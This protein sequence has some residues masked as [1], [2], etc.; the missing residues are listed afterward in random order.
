MRTQFR[1]VIILLL[2]QF[3][4]LC[5]CAPQTADP[6]YVLQL[7]TK[8]NHDNL[9]DFHAALEVLV[10]PDNFIYY[11]DIAFI[12]SFEDGAY[13]QTGGTG[14][15]RYGIRDEAG[16]PITVDIREN[17]T[18]EISQANLFTYGGEPVY[19]MPQRD[20]FVY[21]PENGPAQRGERPE[22]RKDPDYWKQ[23]T[24]DYYLYNGIRY[25][26]YGIDYHRENQP[27]QSGKIYEVKW[28]YGKYEISLRLGGAEL[29]AYSGEY[30]NSFIG[31]LLH[32]DT[33]QEA[34]DQINHAILWR[35]IQV[36]LKKDAPLLIC[37]LCVLSAGTVVLVKG[38][39][40][41]KSRKKQAG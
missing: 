24:W 3:L 35:R 6:E 2:L 8:E 31:K 22:D 1:C 26:Y 34:V 29:D 10:I 5:G 16:N 38:R 11:E 14:M 9:D 4:L 39:K 30:R 40:R 33:V 13:L 36:A 18:K 41:K 27:D 23:D 19:Q 15:Q 37:L 7:A 21:A 28:T 17:R 20:S 12:G 25:T 32:P